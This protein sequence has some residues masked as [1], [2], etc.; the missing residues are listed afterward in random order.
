MIVFFIDEGEDGAGDK[1]PTATSSFG[2][3]PA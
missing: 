1:G 3:I 2:L